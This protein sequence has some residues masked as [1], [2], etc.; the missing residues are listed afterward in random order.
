MLLFIMNEKRKCL[1]LAE[2]EVM[3]FSLPITFYYTLLYTTGKGVHHNNQKSDT[4][5]VSS[6]RGLMLFHASLS[7]VHS[8]RYFRISEK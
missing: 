3:F 7:Q 2:M 5:G 4:Y 8:R 6:K 1:F